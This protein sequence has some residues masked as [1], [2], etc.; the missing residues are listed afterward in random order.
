MTLNGSPRRLRFGSFD[1]DV[2][3]GQLLR[4]GRPVKI[5]PQPFRVL[6]I[7]A[8]HAGEI[9]S[10]DELRAQIWDTATFVEFDQ[11]LNYCI[12]QIRLALGDD[13]GN[14]V[15]LE[16]VKKRGYRFIAPVTADVET[17]PPVRAGFRPVVVTALVLVAVTAGSWLFPRWMNANRTPREPVRD[18]RPITDF[19]D[20]AMA[21]ALSP[22][23]R[24]VAFIRGSSSFLTPDQIYLKMLPDGEARRLTDDPRLKYGPAFSPDGSEVAYTVMEHM[25]WSTYAVSVLGGEPRLVLS[26]AAGLTW[27]DRN[28]LLFSQIKKGQHMGIV[29]G[30]E[31][32][33]GL[34]EL[35]F[36]AHERAMAHY[37][38]A[39]PDRQSALVV[40]MSK[41]GPW[42]SCRLISLNAR[43]ESRTAGPAGMCDAAGWSPD[44]QWMY[45]TVTLDG[46]HHVWRQRYPD[47]TPEQLTFGPTSE[48][49]I[50]IDRDGKSLVTSLGVRESTLWVHDAGGDRQLSS[51]GKVASAGGFSADGQFVYY[52]LQLESE[53][54]RRQLRR[55]AVGIG[56]SEALFPGVSVLEFDVSPDG[57]HAVYTTTTAGGTSQLW[58]AP[59]DGSAPPSA[60]G[61]SGETSPLFGPDG[62]ILFR[63]TEG[64]FNYLGRMN[65]D[66]SGRAKVVPY[67]ISEIQGASPS[68]NWVMAIAPLLDN[69]TVAPMAIPVHG[70]N[71]VRICEIYCQTAWS[72]NGRF[73][74]ASV[75]EPSLSSPGRT[76]AIPVGPGEALP[77]FPA[78][79]IRP[80]SDP[81]VMPG[82]RLVKRAEFIP[83]ADP[84][85]FVYVQNSVH[86]NLFRIALQ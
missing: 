47:G 58:I 15:Y 23:G 52:V 33:D 56:R 25:G 81:G 51:E 36:P 54:V 77:D 40:E 70:G 60:I 4:D 49:G 63:F 84:D 21:P 64:R 80:L 11:G 59:T 83:G 78:S 57:T 79:G 3:S 55:M 45:F 65:P 73:L 35:Y 44:G 53:G 74:F 16:T 42:V 68:R 19:A 5:Q 75:E 43:F 38:S 66:G 30:P 31:T 26:N 50:A 69:S 8:G 85:T 17:P 48:T 6:V 41:D 82:A 12:R 39:S 32:R 18:I 27:L 7:L 9:V 86:R 28:H 72:T 61:A 20:S 46:Q 29:A 62:E 1:L 34:R 37:S 13:A 14:P 22:D 2:R 10:R 67:P 76:L 24:M 71:P